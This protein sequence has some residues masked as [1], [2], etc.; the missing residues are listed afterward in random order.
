MVP[1]SF[2]KVP[3]HTI[4][5]LKGTLNDTNHCEV[6]IYKR[7]SR[8]LN[9]A[10][11]HMLVLVLR[12]RHEWVKRSQLNYYYFQF[13]Q[14]SLFVF[15]QDGRSS[16]HE[17]AEQCHGAIIKELIQAGADVNLRNEVSNP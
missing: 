11:H 3:Y 10:I 1:V 5:F 9:M 17:T 13:L 2:Q 7:L 8:I 12:C 16:L 14:R 4:S 6:I 15:S